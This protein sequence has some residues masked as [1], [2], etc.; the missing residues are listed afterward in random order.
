MKKLY[1]LIIAVLLIQCFTGNSF[2]Q[3]KGWDTC[4]NSG[5]FLPAYTRFDDIY[6]FNKDTGLVVSS[7]GEI[8][9]TWDG[10]HNWQGKYMSSSGSTYF[11][12]IEFTNNCQYGIAGALDGTVFRTQDRGETWTDISPVISDTGAGIR[13]ICGLAHWGNNT[14]YGVGWW[15]GLVARFYKSTNAGTSWTQLNLTTQGGV[16]TLTFDPSDANILYAGAAPG[17]ASLWV[18]AV[19][20]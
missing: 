4:I 19:T 15:G 16:C 6:F 3:V 1:T 12:S 20:T 17:F 11:R 5:L 14:F 2:A 8:F 7:Y 13:R 9:K 18:E 10:G